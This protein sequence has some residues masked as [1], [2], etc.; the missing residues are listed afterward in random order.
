MIDQLAKILAEVTEKNVYV[1]TNPEVPDFTDKTPPE[2][3]FYLPGGKEVSLVL[4]D[5]NLPSVVPMLKLSIFGKGNKIV[6]WDWKGLA[7]YV[8][9]KTKKPLMVE[10]AIIDLKIIESYLG[11]KDQP[12]K[13]LVEALNRLKALITKGLWKEVEG[14]YKRLHMPLLTAVIPALETVGII[15]PE[16]GGK[17]HAHYEIDGQENGRLKCRGVFGMSYVPH[18]MTQ[19]FKARAKPTA[20]ESLFMSFDFVGQEVY[21]L[22]WASKDPLLEELCKGKDVYEGIFERVAGKKCEGKES[23]DK[24]KKFFL[25]VIYGQSAYMLSQR[26]NIPLGVAERIKERI[27]AL[28][29]VALA[30]VGA[31]QKRLNEDGYARDI[32]GKRRLHFEE[33]KEFSVRNFSV[34]SPSAVVCLEKLVQLHNAL[35]GKAEIAYSLHDGYVIYV[36]KENWRSIFKIGHEVLSGDS[37]FCPGLRLRVVCRA[38]RNLNDLKPLAR[39][40]DS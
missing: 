1:R 32:F 28:F 35:K 33:G 10:G 16:K 39:K 4:S 21:F 9:A 27:D 18:A 25:P 24:A 30:W 6:A 40:G 23:R 31:S 29:P 7:S 17:V 26:L 19:D 36:N 20:L 15:D 8:L 34:Q 11:I 3:V 5:E 14:V 12:P 22:S 37:E 38:G 13:K 2:L